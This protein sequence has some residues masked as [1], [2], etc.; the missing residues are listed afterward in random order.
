MSILRD[1]RFQRG[2]GTYPL[3]G[4]RLADA[5]HAALDAGY[6]AFD[7]AQMY[8]NES[9]LGAAIANSGI[10]R[11]E[12]CITTKVQPSNFGA[13]F[14]PSVRSSLRKLRLDSVDVLLLHWPPADGVVKPSLEQLA[15]ARELCLARQIG[16]S[17]YTSAMLRKAVAV[18]G[19]DLATN[20][21]EFHPLL[22]QDILLAAADSLGIPL[23]A[24]CSV[25][26]GEVFKIPD[27]AEIGKPHG[28]SAGQVVLRWIL[29]KGVCPITMSTNPANIRANFDITDF[30]LSDEDMARI[31]KLTFRNR[32]IVN[33]DLVP[34]APDWD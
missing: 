32:R 23:S 27:F 3:A 1:D 8:G 9:D 20:Q 6:R 28:K 30:S 11:E 22:N 10:P 31:H 18:V 16:V 15:E 17:N 7:T 13:S 25:A 21:V 33:K 2:F 24:Y 19:P 14:I 26:R 34:T 5:V 4:K 29:Q 12:L